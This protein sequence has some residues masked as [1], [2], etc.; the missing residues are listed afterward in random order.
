MAEGA[1]RINAATGVEERLEHIPSRHGLLYSW[2]ARPPRTEVC[3]LICTSILGDFATN[4][5]RER[6]LARALA[7]QGIGVVRFHYSGEGNS[8]GDR[9]NMTFTSL[10][11]D[12]NAVLDHARSLG[13]AHFA[14]LGTRLGAFVAAATVASADL[15]PL[16]LW[17]PPTDPLRFITEAHRARRMSQVAQGESSKAIHWNQELE[18]RA[19]S[20]PWV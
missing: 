4:Y 8:Q 6:L 10:C 16:A 12:S 2:V 13:F 15:I 11:D 17:E 19:R 1:T 3:V 7:A 9:A 18:Q 14:F 20:P 5:H